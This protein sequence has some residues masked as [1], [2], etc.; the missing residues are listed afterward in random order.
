MNGNS[1]KLEPHK[2]SLGMDANI[3]ALLVYLAT[4]V[5][6][7]IPGVKYVAWLAPLVLFLIE[8][9]SM[10]VKFHALQAF[11]LN[12]FGAV[13]GFVVAIIFGGIVA[14][15]VLNPLG[16]WGAAAFL[17]GLIGVLTIVI[18]IAITVFTIIAMVKAYGYTEYQ[19][20]L[21]GKLAKKYC[22]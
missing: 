18:S 13:I 10:F 12:L 7:W 1:V 11:V 2:S 4:G 17:T 9:D 15:M 14:A 22:K 5:L 3:L 21:L 16:G 20:P 8:K 19:I 6:S